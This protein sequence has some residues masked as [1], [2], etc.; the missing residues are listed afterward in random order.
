MMRKVLICQERR[1]RVYLKFAKNDLLSFSCYL[2]YFLCIL[3]FTS[4]IVHHHRLLMI[5]SAAVAVAAAVV[6][7][8]LTMLL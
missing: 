4:S 3:C 1:E 5:A 2:L 7:D 6:A 8:G